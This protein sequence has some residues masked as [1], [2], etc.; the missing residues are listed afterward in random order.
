MS[1]LLLQILRSLFSILT[2]LSS[3]RKILSLYVHQGP[4]LFLPSEAEDTASLLRLL[5][6]HYPTAVV[7]VHLMERVQKEQPSLL[8][9]VQL[10]I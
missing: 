3:E 4:K 9:C 7:Q 8:S 10:F 1:S 6:I 5:L 2:L